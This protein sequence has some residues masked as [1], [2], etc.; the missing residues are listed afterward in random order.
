[1]FRRLLNILGQARSPT[2]RVAP[3][4]PES[5][6]A[7][8]E[9]NCTA[10]RRAAAPESDAEFR[11]LPTRGAVPSAHGQGAHAEATRG[12]RSP[13]GSASGA[14]CPVEHAAAETQRSLDASSTGPAAPHADSPDSRTRLARRAA[15]VV[16]AFRPFIQADGG[17]VDFVGVTEK[18]VVQVRLR[19][20]CRG[21]PSSFLT[22]QMGLERALLEHMPELRGVEDVG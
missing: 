20:A 5:S 8:P 7:A 18:N 17:D 22:L 14:P 3:A 13:S 16:D 9:S 12:G 21:C 11:D 4:A 15:E 6:A 1:M 19:G 10:P 2:E